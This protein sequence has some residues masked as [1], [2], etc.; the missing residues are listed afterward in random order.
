MS[1]VGGSG[2]VAETAA[3]PAWLRALPHQSERPD[4]ANRRHLRQ[5]PIFSASYHVNPSRSTLGH[6]IAI[7]YPR[8]GISMSVLFC[9]VILTAIKQFRLREAPACQPRVRAWTKQEYPRSQTKIPTS[10]HREIYMA[11]DVLITRT[12]LVV[13]LFN[14]VIRL[15]ESP[16][17]CRISQQRARR[18]PGF[19]I[20][21]MDGLDC[22]RKLTISRSCM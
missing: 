13:P 20:P 16:L 21:K 11:S 7:P 14:P 9:H 6:A 10:M 22:G 19:A 3:A 2:K 17:C 18:K 5:A 1:E 8:L 4:L 12:W 15:A